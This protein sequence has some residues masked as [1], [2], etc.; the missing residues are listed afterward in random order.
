MF[1]SPGDVA[2]VRVE[3]P[4]GEPIAHAGD[5]SPGVARLGVEELGG[6]RKA[7]ASARVQGQCWARR[8]NTRRCPRVMRAAVGVANRSVIRRRRGG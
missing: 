8:R 3:V 5:V 6:D 4:M 1:D 2:V 7:R